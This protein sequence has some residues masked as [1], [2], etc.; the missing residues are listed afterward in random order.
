[1]A[2]QS[3]LTGKRSAQFRPRHRFGF[4]FA[5]SISFRPSR[6]NLYVSSSFRWMGFRKNIAEEKS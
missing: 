4:F 6:L 1:M 2:S 3:N 5:A